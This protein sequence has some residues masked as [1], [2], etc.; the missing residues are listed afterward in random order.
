[1]AFSMMDGTFPNPS[2][3]VLAYDGGNLQRGGFPLVFAAV[4][5]PDDHSRFGGGIWQGGAGLAAG[6]DANQNNNLYVST[7]DGQFG[8]SSSSYGDSFLKLNT[9]L[10]L[11]DYFT[12]A[13][14][15][16]RW[17]FKCSP[18]QGNDQDLGSGGEMMVP[19]GVLQD[20]H[21]KNIVIKGEKEGNIWV[22]D[23]THIGGAGNGCSIACESSCGVNPSG[24]WQQFPIT[25]TMARSAP[26]FWS[27]GTTPFMYIAQQYTQ[28]YQYKLNCAYPNGPICSPASA[29]TNVDP[30]GS[31]IGYA[32]T[33]V[34]IVEWNDQWDRPGVGD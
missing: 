28:L 22:I 7:G 3:W 18:P 29:T 27:D 30:T 26:A 19:D 16:Y 25:G 10:Q 15:D 33:A 2:G 20:S 8:A 24:V 17:D 34:G 32:T 23:R 6:L 13:D 21:Y 5:N 4:Q 11:A 12:P 14:W 9:E 31:Q 1:M